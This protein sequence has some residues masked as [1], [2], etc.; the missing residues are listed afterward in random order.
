MEKV[1]SYYFIFCLYFWLLFAACI[2]DGPYDLFDWSIEWL[3]D[4]VVAYYFFACFCGLIDWLSVSVSVR[5]P[6][7]PRPLSKK[8]LEAFRRLHPHPL[9]LAVKGL[10]ESL[11]AKNNSQPSTSKGPQSTTDTGAEFDAAL[12][13]EDQTGP[14]SVSFQGYMERCEENCPDTSSEGMRYITLNYRVTPSVT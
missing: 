6:P 7:P 11:I 2:I 5:L 9:D 1:V 10:R 14:L 13:A 12:A 3:I 4:F 8:M